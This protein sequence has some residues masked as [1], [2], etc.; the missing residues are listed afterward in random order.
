MQRVRQTVEE[1]EAALTPVE[2]S[3]R[4]ETAD[5]VIERLK[6][7]PAKPAYARVDI[8]AWLSLTNVSKAQRNDHFEANITA[9]RLFL[10]LSKDEFMGQL[11]EQL[12]PGGCGV[13]RFLA[14]PE[15]FMAAFEK[16][17][18]QEKMAQLVNTPLTWD[19]LL[20]ERLKGGRGSAIKGQRRGRSLEDFVE[21]V[22][23]S[24]FGVEGYHPR[25]RFRGASGLST[26]KADF[27][28]PN[29][30]DPRVL[31]EVKAYG[32]TGSKQTDVL[33][34]IRRIVAEKR[35]DTD[36]LLV[37]DGIT[38]RD[39]LSDLGK[40]VQMQNH[41]EIARIY[42]RSMIERFR[43]ELEQLRADHAL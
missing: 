4:D 37:T 27:A 19:A 43:M 17:E 5:R 14:Q 16:F 3:W 26:E 33:G 25:C 13:T 34:D 7:L 2:S 20:T 30:S 24:V 29:K 42:T 32:A 38:W 11:R 36:F 9:V 28:I 40:L 1:I 8:A 31:I 6:A 18:L 23:K 21:D 39:R 10:D 35:S 41:G 15:S 12:R 22:V